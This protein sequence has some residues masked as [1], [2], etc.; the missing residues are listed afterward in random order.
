MIVTPSFKANSSNAESEGA[1]TVRDEV[2]LVKTGNNSSCIT[3]VTN[4]VKPLSIAISATVSS[5]KSNSETTCTTPLS[6]VISAVETWEWFTY[7]SPALVLVSFKVLVVDR[8]LTTAPLLIP[9]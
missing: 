4:V 2:G 8:G 1:K 7:T 3:A 9:V 5:G 6:A